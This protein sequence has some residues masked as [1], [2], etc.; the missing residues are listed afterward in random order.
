VLAVVG[1]RDPARTKS[2]SRRSSAA[3]ATSV[4]SGR[5]RERSLSAAKTK[6]S[7]LK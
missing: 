7:A 3:S 6:H 4:P 2:P 1:L 5:L